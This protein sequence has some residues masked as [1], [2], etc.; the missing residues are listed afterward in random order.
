MP[1]DIGHEWAGD[2]TVGSTGDLDAVGG[3][4]A[5]T[6]RILRRLLTNAGDYIWNLTYGAGLP[7]FVGTPESDVQIGAIVR[8][9]LALEASV[10][11]SPA[12]HVT[13]FRPDGPGGGT[14]E[15]AIRYTDA[16]TGQLVATTL[17]VTG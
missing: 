13:V 6:Q 5:V 1:L 9:Q 11:V 15:V 12:S 17:P 10:A 7:R 14:F 2:L 3:P 8:H 4:T 16:S